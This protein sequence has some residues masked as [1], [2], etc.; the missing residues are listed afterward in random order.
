[1]RRP[2]KPLAAILLIIIYLMLYYTWI[3]IWQDHKPML[4]W[5][6][7]VLTILAGIAALSWLLAAYRRGG[8]DC[9]PLWLLL[10]LGCLSSL[11][12]NIIWLYNNSI[13]QEE[14]PFPSV[15]D[16]FYVL[17]PLFYLSAFIYQISRKLKTYGAVRFVFDIAIVMTAAISLSWQY[18]LQP[19]VSTPGIPTFNM[20]M[21]L[22]YPI[23]DL[24]LL[25]SAL[26]IYFGFRTIWPERLLS[27]LFAGVLTQIIG[28]C[29]FSVTV[30]TQDSSWMIWSNPCFGLSLLLI[31]LTG[32]VYKKSLEKLPSQQTT[33]PVEVVEKPNWI[34]TLLPYITVIALFIVMVVDSNSRNAIALGS[35]LSILFVIIRQLLI[36]LENRMLLVTL[37]EKTIALESSEEQYRSL[38]RYHPDAVC[39]LDLYG[40]ILSINESASRMLGYS[41]DELDLLTNITFIPEQ[42]RDMARMHFQQSWKGQPQS[43]ELCLQARDGRLIQVQMTNIPIMIQGHT[44]GAFAIAKDITEK[45]NNE[46]RIHYLAYH[47]PLTGVYNR[48]AY[49]ENLKWMIAQPH[50]QRFAVF[51]IDLDRFKHVND[52]L[53][54]D[55]GDQLLLSVAG[56]LTAHVPADSMVARRG[57]DEFTLLLPLTD[58]DRL[59]TDTAQA[60][61]ES[62]QQPHY[63]GQHKIVC[64]PSIGIA[65]YP[66]H[67]TDICTLVQKADRAMYQV[68]INGKAHYLIYDDNDEKITRKLL[69]E[70]SIGSA[71]DHNELLL[72]YQSQ[73]D[74]SSGKVVG[75]EA[76]LRW[77]HPQLGWIAPLE[78]IPVAEDTGSIL[79]I[80]RWVL[81]E[82][83]RQA[84]TW[85]D[86]GHF[87]K[88]GVNL[89]PRQF[90]Q[91]NLVDTVAEVLQETGLDPAYLDLEITESIAMSHI[92]NVIPQL[93]ALKHLGVSISIDDFGTGYSSLSYLASFPIDKLKIAREFISK[94]NEKD[95]HSIIA[96]IINLAYGLNL[97]V[98]A[99]GVEDC[100]QAD[101]LKGIDCY[102]MQGYLFSKP[103]IAAEIEKTFQQDHL[104]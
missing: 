97:N 82:A 55:V 70:Q 19:I 65:I 29:M 86:Q 66:D 83:C 45:K 101:I 89:S 31:G 47:D 103:V 1:M 50:I 4:D 56:R 73:V 99:E 44:V 87:I 6:G 7:D 71:L 37:S 62:L 76:L 2:S 28:D 104:H 35:G 53:G 33:L 64:T 57:G 20:S 58:D 25:L 67:S 3:L 5:G 98:I 40:N 77:K 95:S 36:L 100:Q 93:H 92:H 52:T 91:G 26:G 90:Q 102:E 81:L 12:A 22:A 43:Y 59:I 8:Q 24:V 63:I 41:E 69:L 39:S 48:A 13:L 80:G 32:I 54:H 79:S 27:L 84:K 17:Q 85:A 16:I 18:V 30:Y 21:A 51:F 46:E 14:L 38:F 88:M 10:M 78:F 96:S 94:I 72:H 68:K 75:V 49:D 23:G 61:L 60:V 9:R 11:I 74:A 42:Y 15:A 34:R